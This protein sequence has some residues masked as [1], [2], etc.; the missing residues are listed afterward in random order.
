MCQRCFQFIDFKFKTWSNTN[1]QLAP[2]LEGSRLRYQFL[3]HGGPCNRLG[4]ARGAGCKYC[5]LYFVVDR[6]TLQSIGES[7]RGWV[8][9]LYFV[10]CTWY[11]HIAINWGSLRGSVQ[12]LYLVFYILHFVFCTCYVHVA[13]DWGM[14]KGAECKSYF[15]GSDVTD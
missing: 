14:H 4:N 2:G 11:V 10:F 5:I 1:V 12:M 6:C 9:M 3:I 13:I 8:Q 15:G 7:I